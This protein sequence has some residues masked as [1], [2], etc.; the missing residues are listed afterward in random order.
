MCLTTRDRNASICYGNCSYGYTLYIIGKSV[1]K[2]FSR[3]LTVLGDLICCHTSLLKV[4]TECGRP[5]RFEW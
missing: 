3:G 1:V 4:F 2:K 5:T